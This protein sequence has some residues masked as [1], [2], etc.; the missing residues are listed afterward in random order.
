MRYVYLALVILITLAVL[1]FKFQN[2][3]SVTVSFL[4]ASMT[5]PLSLLMVGV[6]F[7]GMFTGGMVVSLV[8]SWVKGATQSSVK[9]G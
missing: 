5:A 4:S 8:R 7:L 9:A 1:A 6:Y 2:I 3:E